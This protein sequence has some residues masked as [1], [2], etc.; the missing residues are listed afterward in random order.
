[1]QNHAMVAEP[2]MAILKWM[3]DCGGP[4]IATVPR[5]NQESVATLFLLGNAVLL[6]VIVALIATTAFY[7]QA[8]S[9]NVHP[10]K[11]ASVPFIAAGLFLAVGHLAS[12]GL[13]ELAIRTNASPGTLSMMWLMLHAFLVIAY[14]LLIRCNW[15]A[16]T[17]SVRSDANENHTSDICSD[18]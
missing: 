1:M 2:P 4:I 6:I 13:N 11:A 17:K 7:R 14:L 10:G 8:K 15:I 16:L 18:S 9:V 3:I 12:F 5:L